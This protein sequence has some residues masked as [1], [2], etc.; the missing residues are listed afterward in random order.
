MKRNTKY[1]FVEIGYM[2]IKKEILKKLTIKDINFSY[3]LEKISKK[4]FGL[5]YIQLNSYL[6]IGDQKRLLKT[7]R[8]F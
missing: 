6:S 7:K 2:A 1:P 5:D 4:S 3:F 8:Y